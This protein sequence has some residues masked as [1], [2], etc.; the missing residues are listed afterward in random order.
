MVPITAEELNRLLGLKGEIESFRNAQAAIV[1]TKEA[2]RLKAIADKDG[3]EKA[4]EVQRQAWE[5]KMGE[6]QSSFTKVRDLY[7][8][9]A[10]L[11]AIGGPLAG[12]DFAG[13][14]PELKAISASQFRS[15]IEPRFE[16][17]APEYQHFFT[18]KTRGGSGTDGTRTAGA[19]QT[20]VNP[21]ENPH[22]IGTKEWAIWR[23]Q[24]ANQA[25]DPLW[26]KPKS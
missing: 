19:G 15:L 7:H 6:A 24:N 25:A 18:A 9:K 5:A 14:K 10:K 17:Y 11:E 26:R 8:G 20:Q 12:V 13:E 16:T 1:A 23:Y 4:L 22:Q 3:A 21:G 2:E